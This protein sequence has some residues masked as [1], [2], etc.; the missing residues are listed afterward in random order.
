MKV[1]FPG[2]S[3]TALVPAQLDV[4]L[5]FEHMAAVGSALGAGGFAVSD[6]KT[7]V[8]EPTLLFCRF[9]HVE[10]CAQCPRAS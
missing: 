7:C 10:S 3:S 1:I 4:P 8:V 5:S 9:L 6:G 2:A